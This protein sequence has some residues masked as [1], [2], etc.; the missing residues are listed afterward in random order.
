MQI[1]SNIATIQPSITK[2]TDGT[3]S[4]AIESVA[5]M[6]TILLKVAGTPI[7]NDFQRIV[8]F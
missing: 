7:F 5:S 3:L 2:T 4:C 1:H 6:V 8:S